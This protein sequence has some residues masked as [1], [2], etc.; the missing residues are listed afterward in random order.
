MN[1][2]LLLTRLFLFYSLS[3]TSQMALQIGQSARL[4]TVGTHEMFLN[5]TGKGSGS[6]VILEAGTGDTSEVWTAVQKGVREFARVC[7]YDRLGLGKS[8]KLVAPHTADEI[9]GD[10]HSLLQA[11]PIP[12]PYIM[13]GHSI[14]GIY[15]R[16]FAALYPAEVLGIVLLDSAHEEQFSRVSALSP[17]WAQ[18]IASKFPVDDQRAHG[19]LLPNQRLV[20]RFDKPLVVIEH[21]EIPSSAASDPMAKQSET[22]F[23]VL[24]KDLANRSK[25]GQLREA[26]QRGHYIQRDQP[27]LVVQAI[28]D[29]MSD[30]T[31]RGKPG[32]K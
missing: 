27:D 1:P 2:S 18:R 13:V 5:C 20:W 14:G 26:R 25:Y 11:V 22:V 28:K 8:D 3:V 16:K 9:V 17:E 12:P 15:V 6:T 4:V 24:Q 19:F 30:S 21:G 32:D 7:S 23:H 10:I 31:G 29:V